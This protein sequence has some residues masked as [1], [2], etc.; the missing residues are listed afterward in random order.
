MCDWDRWLGPCPWRPYNS[1]YVRGRWRGHFDFHGG[2]ILEWGSHTVDLCQWAAGK[3]DTAPVEY[4][5]NARRSRLHL[6]RRSEAGHAQRRL[7]GHGHVQRPLRG[8]RR[9]DRDGRQRQVRPASRIAAH[10]SRRSSTARAPIRPPTS[11]TSSTAS[12]PA[13]WPTPTRPSSPSRTSSATP[14]TSPGNSAAR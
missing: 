2:G 8:R 3:D 4:V 9:L 12:R 14:P 7:D 13:S 11:A 1:Q 5:P 6:R 10:R